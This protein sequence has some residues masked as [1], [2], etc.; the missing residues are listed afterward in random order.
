MTALSA[1]ATL[2]LRNTT[3]K[4]VRY[5]KVKTSAICYT[6]SICTISAANNTVVV[7]ANAT[8]GRYCGI[9][10]SAGPV[11]GDGTRTVEVVDNCEILCIA[12]TTVTKAL[13]NDAMYAQD[14]GSV[15]N[16][17]TLGPA[18]GTLIE[19]VASTSVWVALRSPT[20][21]DAT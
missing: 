1:N 13:F 11:T 7:A 9:C 15:T 4:S 18:I 6:G 3:G 21:L 16:L 14:D 20:L 19:W 8:T 10:T 17:T 2:T 5:Y 12:A